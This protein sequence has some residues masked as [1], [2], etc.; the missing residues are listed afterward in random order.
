MMPH[1]ELTGAGTEALIAD[2]AGLN[3]Q[4]VLADPG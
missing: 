2:T 3:D 4:D 1:R